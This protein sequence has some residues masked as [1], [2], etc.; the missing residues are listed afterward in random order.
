MRSAVV[1]R[2]FS[3]NASSVATSPSGA[4]YTDLRIN[5][6]KTGLDALLEGEEIKQALFEFEHDLWNF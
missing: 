3:G 4:T 1:S 6:Y 2:T 5:E